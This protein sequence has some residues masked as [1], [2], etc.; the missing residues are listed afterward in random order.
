[1]SDIETVEAQYVSGSRNMPDDV[2]LRAI[3]KAKLPNGEFRH[4][5]HIR[6]AWLFLESADE[7]S[8]AQRMRT[9]LLS[10]AAK[11]HGDIAKYHETITRAFMRLVASSRDAIGT[12]HSFDE[13]ITRFPQLL[14]KDALESYYSKQTLM[15]P[16][17][18]A[19]F[20]PPDLQPLP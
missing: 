1:M 17:A 7:I 13:F 19:A 16:E 14:N 18:R 5:D 20:V 15:S 2:F 4:F 3:E 8:A 6:L 12:D 9:T 10:F 11:H